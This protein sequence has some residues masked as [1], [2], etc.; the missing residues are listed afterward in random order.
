MIIEWEENGGLMIKS[1]G[2]Y[3]CS[4]EE[5]YLSRKEFDELLEKRP[6]VEKKDERI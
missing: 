5:C 1:D 2:C 3:D 4:G 6:A